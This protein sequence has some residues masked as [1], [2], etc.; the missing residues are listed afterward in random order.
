MKSAK[1]FFIKIAKYTLILLAVLMVL[2]I[3]F[4]VLIVEE[5]S[6]GGSCGI[7]IP[8]KDLYD[9]QGCTCIGK[10]VERNKGEG[11]FYCKGI[12]LYEGYE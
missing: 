1:K 6:W 8:S 4:F 5:I 10:L 7:N 2:L 12:K 11:F 9:S 3:I